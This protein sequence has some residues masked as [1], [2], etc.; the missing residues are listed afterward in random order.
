M[1]MTVNTDKTKVMI[2]KSK[3]ITYNTFIYDN[4][5][6][7]EVPSYKYQNR[8]SSQAQL[9]YSIEKRIN[10]GWKAYYGLENNCKSMDLWIWDKK[11]LLFETLITPVILYGCEVWG[12]SISRESWRKI[13]Q[14]Q[15]NFITYNLK[16]KG[17]TPYPILLIEVSLS[18][19]ESMTMTRYLMYKNK[20]NNMEDK[21]LPK[22][23]SN[24]SQNHLRLKQGWHKDAQSWLNHWGIKE[25]IILE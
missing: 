12:C 24:S 1:G 11:K 13:E 6:L 2:I 20:L 21:R 4:N 25:E 3:K 15:K 17:N 23:A 14:I 10:G 8:Y 16:I 5:N 19:I 9:N 7:E 18:P 22:I